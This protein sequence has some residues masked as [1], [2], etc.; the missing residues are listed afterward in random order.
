VAVVDEGAAMCGGDAGG[1]GGKEA[2]DV[3]M[4]V[5]RFGLGR[6][7]GLRGWDIFT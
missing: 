3:G 2:S 1:G 5:S 4:A 7:T 6:D